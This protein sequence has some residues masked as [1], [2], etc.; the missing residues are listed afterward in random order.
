MFRALKQQTLQMQKKV[1][2]SSRT[3]PFSTFQ[4][5]DYAENV[6]IGAAQVESRSP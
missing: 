3:N 2:E 4:R 1:F 5:E 6:T